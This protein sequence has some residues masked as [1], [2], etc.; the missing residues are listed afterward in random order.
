[1]L[2]WHQEKQVSIPIYTYTYVRVRACVCIYVFLQ[3]VE[4]YA[5]FFPIP[6]RVERTETCLTLHSVYSV[7]QAEK[8]N[9]RQ[10]VLATA[11][12]TGTSAG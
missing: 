6:Q 11:R 9:T 4:K 2:L 10:S 1:M 12:A 7:W 5:T 8:A 3:Y